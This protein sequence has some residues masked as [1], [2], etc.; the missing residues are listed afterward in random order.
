MHRPQWP[1]PGA[2]ILTAFAQTTRRHGAKPLAP[3][4]TKPKQRP[5]SPES[6]EERKTGIGDIG[7]PCPVRCGAAPFWP[8]LDRRASG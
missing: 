6:A 2:T 7:A 1:A 5:D 8:G 4:G 3:P